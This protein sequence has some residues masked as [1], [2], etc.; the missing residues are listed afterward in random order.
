MKGGLCQRLP[1]GP[2]A[3]VLGPDHV[4]LGPG[5]LHGVADLGPGRLWAHCPQGPP[6]VGASPAMQPGRTVRVLARL[7]VKPEGGPGEGYA[8]PT[9]VYGWPLRAASRLGLPSSPP[10]KRRPLQM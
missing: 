1:S 10:C 5:L 3:T 2:A 4:I 6:T 7:G 8:T 9:G